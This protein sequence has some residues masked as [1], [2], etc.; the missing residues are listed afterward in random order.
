MYPF[1]HVFMRSALQNIILE[2]V[3]IA[4]PLLL[5]RVMRHDR[6]LKKYLGVKKLTKRI[7]YD[8]V[9]NRFLIRGNGDLV[10]TDLQT[11]QLLINRIKERIR[12]EL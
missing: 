7:F 11:A 4:R 3:R 2:E 6:E 5:F 12:Y 10:V 1:Y 8:M 9:D